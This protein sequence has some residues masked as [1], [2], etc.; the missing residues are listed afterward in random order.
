MADRRLGEGWAVVVYAGALGLLII[1]T[2]LF[3]MFR[4]AT[5]SGQGSP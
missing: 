2:D 4:K 3:C 1:A 5:V